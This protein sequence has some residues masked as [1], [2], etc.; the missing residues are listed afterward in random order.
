MLVV[1][2]PQGEAL[3]L[4]TLKRD[5]LA[6][7]GPGALVEGVGQGWNGG[8]ALLSSQLR[9]VTLLGVA[10]V[11]LVALAAALNCLAEVVRFARSIAPVSVVS[12]SRRVYATVAVWTLAVPLCV[13]AVLGAVSA[14]WVTLPYTTAPRNG[15]LPPQML[16]A[17]V[18]VLS[19]LAAAVASLAAMSA[20]RESRRW[21][22][23]HD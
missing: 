11:A 3:P 22:P 4:G 18:V 2:S 8:A 15:R 14:V 5:A 19:V 6:V 16:T 1:Y 9:W 17:A 20:V 13:A 10:G 12:G 7:L 23:R 21:R